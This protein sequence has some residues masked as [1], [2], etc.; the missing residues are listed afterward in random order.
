MTTRNKHLQRLQKMTM[1]NKHLQKATKN[2]YKKQAPTKAT[3]N[4]Y[5]KQATP[6]MKCK[7][8]LDYNFNAILQ[9]KMS[10]PIGDNIS[11]IQSSA[12][13]GRVYAKGDNQTGLLNSRNTK[14]CKLYYKF[15]L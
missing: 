13:S 5:E 8:S 2:D 9:L 12:M 4:D 10:N 7:T 1:R 14:Q 6:W 11:C 3:K 15:I